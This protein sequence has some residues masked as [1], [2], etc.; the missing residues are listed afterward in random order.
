MDTPQIR[1]ARD[2]RRRWNLHADPDNSQTI[3]TGHAFPDD[4]TG[5][6]ADVSGQGR[7]VGVSLLRAIPRVVNRAADR[8]LPEKD[9]PW[10]QRSLRRRRC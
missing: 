4:W 3:S 10:R 9:S 2:Q 1:R 6:S 5:A 7:D 8:S